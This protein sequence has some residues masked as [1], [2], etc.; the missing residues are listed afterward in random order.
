MSRYF[1]VIAVA[2]SGSAL[3]DVKRDEGVRVY[4]LEMSRRITPFKDL[5]SLFRMYF[6]LRNEKPDIVHTH[7][8][9]AGF[10]GMLAARLAGVRHRLHTVAGM[11]LMETTGVKQR[12]L[13]Q[14]EKFTYRCATLVLP[15]SLGL[16]NYILKKKFTPQGKIHMIANGSS[17]GINLD[18][19]NPSETIVAQAQA[20]RK[21]YEIN[22]QSC[23]FLFI[24]R[25]VADKGIN[26]L[27]NAFNRLSQQYSEIK[28]LLVG[29][30]EKLDPVSKKTNTI[31]EKNPDIIFCGFQSDVR[32]LLAMSDIFVFP[33]YREGFPNVVL[34]ACSF[35]L[36]SIVTN[37]N[38][39]NEIIEH[40]VN[41][42]LI[43]PKN[44]DALY[45]SMKQL[46]NDKRLRTKLGGNSRGV[47]K[48]KYDQTFVWHE[49]LC[50]YQSLLR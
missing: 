36:P 35:N 10:V 16:M 4:A 47:I 45:M 6:L 11:P 2:S 38:G 21:Q 33:S 34:Q 1:D 37:I 48:E 5:I 50:L 12:L 40:A 7:T 42:L 17:N 29:Q 25:I 15:N 24:G 14:I 23:V 31:I 32:P 20:L 46:L 30:E 9:K 13:I 43:E 28:L 26:E 44:S 49:L 18:Y 3:E 27:V 41:G 8:P 19:F 22:S 39:N